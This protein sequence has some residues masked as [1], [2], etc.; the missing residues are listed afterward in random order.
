MH[1]VRLMPLNVFDEMR[2]IRCFEVP[3]DRAEIILL[4]AAIWRTPDVIGTA[5]PIGGL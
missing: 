3:P 4:E 1:L 5:C 2:R